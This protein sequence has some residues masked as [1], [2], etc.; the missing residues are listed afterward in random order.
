MFNKSVIHSSLKRIWAREFF[1]SPSYERPVNG[2][3]KEMSLL[4]YDV[5]E[6]EILKT[7]RGMGWHF[8][9]KVNGERLDFSNPTMVELTSDSPF[10]DIQSNKEELIKYID[11]DDYY[12]VYQNFIMAYEETLGLNTHPN[13]NSK[14]ISEPYSKKYYYEIS[15]K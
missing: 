11:Q 14:V 6:G 7:P 10:K 12:T 13:N 5:F 15:Y 2:H 3:D 9:N 4:I 8:Y 1:P